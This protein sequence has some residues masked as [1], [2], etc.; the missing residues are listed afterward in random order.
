MG[1]FDKRIAK[2]YSFCPLKKMKALKICS[3][4]FEKIAEN[5]RKI[6]WTEQLELILFIPKDLNVEKSA[7][8]H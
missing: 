1:V 5:T 2:S 4:I 7:E 3:L 8:K 6:G